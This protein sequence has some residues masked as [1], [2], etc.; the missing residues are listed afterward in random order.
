MN[1]LNYNHSLATLSSYLHK[2]LIVKL[3][4]KFSFFLIRK[5][6]ELQYLNIKKGGKLYASTK[7]T[8]KTQEGAQNE[9][10]YK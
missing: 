1:S 10:L 6:H 9:V 3:L 4:L 7:S 8:S 2:L 5:F